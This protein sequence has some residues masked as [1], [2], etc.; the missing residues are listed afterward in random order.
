MSQF[1]ESLFSNRLRAALKQ[2]KGN[3]QTED[4]YKEINRKLQI[5]SL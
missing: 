5:W 3:S 1:T 2:G 4:M